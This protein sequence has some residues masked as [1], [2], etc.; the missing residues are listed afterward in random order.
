MR[1]F[2]IV[3]PRPWV[4]LPLDGTPDE[5]L[6]RLLDKAFADVPAS[7]PP[8]QIGPMRTNL[9]R[10]IAAELATARSR[11]AVAVY[12]PTESWHHFHNGSSFFVSSLDPDVHVPS[13]V[14]ADTYA[15][16]VMAE[17]LKK[18]GSRVVQT[19]NAAWVRSEQVNPPGTSAELDVPTVSVQYLT[20][21]PEAPGVWASVAFS[22]IG[23]GDPE[24]Q[25]TRLSVELFDA[26]MSTWFWLE[27]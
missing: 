16:L 1:S 25:P 18:P 3:L 12:L 10:R 21:M 7:V 26:I 23:D 2:E 15:P 4:S 14:T 17:L 24:S 11:G 19:A 20:P 13:E 9:E 6:T 8:D 5:A 27:G 22:T